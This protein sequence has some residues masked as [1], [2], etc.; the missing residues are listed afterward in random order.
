MHKRH[1][2]FFKTKSY[3]REAMM[4]GRGGGLKIKAIKQKRGELKRREM[5]GG[6]GGHVIL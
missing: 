2:V 5:Q 6:G 1:Q 4:S 3:H